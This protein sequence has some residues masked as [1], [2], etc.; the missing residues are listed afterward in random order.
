V[1]LNL[2]TCL[3]SAIKWL[4]GSRNIVTA[5]RWQP[6][7]STV[8]RHQSCKNSHSHSSEDC[9]GV[10]GQLST[11]WDQGRIDIFGHPCNKGLFHLHHVHILLL[12]LPP[13]PLDGVT[14]EHILVK[15]PTHLSCVLLEPRVNVAA[16]SSRDLGC[17]FRQ[18]SG[19]EL[20]SVTDSSQKTH[21]GPESQFSSSGVF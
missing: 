3:C 14:S 8:D 2:L 21:S 6:C 20:R 7:D 10:C 11:H 16:A 19:P 5:I 9:Y 18:N 4:R 15:W 1:W 13:V 17:K 12:I